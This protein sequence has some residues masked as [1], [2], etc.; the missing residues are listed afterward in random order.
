MLLGLLGPDSGG[1]SHLVVGATRS[2]IRRL[3]AQHIRPWMLE[4]AVMPLLTVLT[5]AD[6]STRRTALRTLEHLANRRFKDGNA[7]VAWHDRQGSRGRLRW[8]LEGFYRRGLPV[9]A[10]ANVLVPLLVDHL[11]GPSEI[12]ARNAEA[13]LRHI[14]RGA[15]IAYVD[16]PSRRH[17]A[18]QRWWQVHQ[19]RYQWPWA[20]RVAANPSLVSERVAL[21]EP[22]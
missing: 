7:A 1:L 20:G 5:D 4:S 9:D 16:T 18:W 3:V 2:R 12:H 13:L 6:P 14:S 21:T 19:R 8:L 11:R 10:P 17:R 22:P 15:L